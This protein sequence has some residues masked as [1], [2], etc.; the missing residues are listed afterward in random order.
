MK[1]EELIDAI[2]ECDLELRSLMNDVADATKTINADEVR[3][4]KTEVLK[5]KAELVKEMAE[6]D[7][8][9]ETK[10]EKRSA[11][12][13]V[14]DALKEKRG[15]TI[16]GTG[17]TNTIRELVKKI[18]DDDSILQ[19]VRY[20]YGANANTVIPVWA[21]NVVAEF[22]SE[23]GAPTETQSANLGNQTII[24]KEAF[25]SLQVSD[26]A[27]DLSAV[28]VESELRGIFSDAFASLMAEKCMTGAAD[29]DMAGIFTASATAYT[30]PITV[31][32]L[33]GLALAVKGKKYR[34]P[35]IVMSSTVYNAFLSDETTGETTKLYK[36]DLIR[37]KSIE[38]V[39][40]VLS[41]Y[42]PTSVSAGSKIAMAGDLSNYAIG[43]AGELKIKPKE[44]AGNSKVTFDAYM[45]FS[46]K[47]LIAA[48]FF[49]YT[50]ANPST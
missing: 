29:G 8:P 34:N 28:D 43:V 17:I 13:D 40:V 22:I 47:P 12:A 37:N 14:V 50:V 21:T 7:K 9:Q 41:P 39:P 18:Q 31:A 44:V 1:K 42:A 20:F 45:Y 35:C 3:A 10:M 48:D 27:L 25:A 19:R 23:S 36:E 46:G 33:G 26:M 24:P 49:A 11:W 16:S 2:N 6:M 5:R 38:G 32:D 4:K 30:K 15:V